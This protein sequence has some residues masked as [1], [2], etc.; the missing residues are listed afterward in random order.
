MRRNATTTTDTARQTATVKET[1][2]EIV[3]RSTDRDTRWRV[4]L[5]FARDTRVAGIY[6]LLDKTA[7]I[8]SVENQQHNLIIEHPFKEDCKII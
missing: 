7:Y 4:F 6:T 8:H 3:A 5:D 2:T 1:E